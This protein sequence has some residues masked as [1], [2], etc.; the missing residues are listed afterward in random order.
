MKNIADDTR[1]S[2]FKESGRAGFGNNQSIN[3]SFR[4]ESFPSNFGVFY[5]LPSASPLVN[6]S[7]SLRCTPSA[8]ARTTAAGNVFACYS[9]VITEIFETD[10]VGKALCIINRRLLGPHEFT[11]NKY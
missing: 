2:V 10:R 6:K 4:F 5:E 8:S 9:V 3:I 11:R 7:C 1:V